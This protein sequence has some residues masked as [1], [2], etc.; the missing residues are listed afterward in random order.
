MSAHAPYFGALQDTLRRHGVTQPTLV[1]DLDRLDQNL[2][3]VLRS[4]RTGGPRPKHLRLVE[5]SLPSPGLLDYLMRRAQTRRLMS[6]HGSFLAQDA[7]HFPDCDVL[8][9][10]PMPVAAAARF[11]AELRGTFDPSRQLQWLIDTP[12]RLAQYLELAQGLNTRLRINLEID[13]GL[14]RGGFDAPPALLPALDLIARHPRH[15]GFAG[16]MGYEPHV[17]LLPRALGRREALLAQAMARYRVL[18]EATRTAH[19]ALWHDT[20]V[21]NTAGSPTYRLHE[22]E[23]LCNEI[24][25]G[26]AL[27]KPGHF[28][29]PTLQDHQPAA[30]I[31]T[32]VL[33]TARALQLPGVPWLSRL[34]AL[35]NPNLRASCFLYGG[36]W[37][38][39][40]VSP[41]GLRSN[42]LYG[43]S[44]NQEIATGAAATQLAVDDLVFL[45][46][47]QS[48]SVLLQFGDLL[49]VRGDRVEAQWPVFAG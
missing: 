49:A 29:L 14:H 35:C 45:R 6:F 37:M 44:S 28:D 33:K 18:V 24:S 27:L 31:A 48:E 3:V 5:K 13:A 1:I 25:V 26:S 11:Y 46:P 36:N 17:A 2:D 23:D 12:Q 34:L 16:F 30:F 4:V 40:Y 41:A 19:P 22:H 39:D 42:R 8:L 9:G 32:P 15:L 47:T 43:R 7:A 21:L 38:A 20:L 10:K